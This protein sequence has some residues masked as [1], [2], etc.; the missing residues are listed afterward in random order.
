MDDFVN[1]TDPWGKGYLG[2]YWA[3]N[4]DQVPEDEEVEDDS[5]DWEKQKDYSMNRRNG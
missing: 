3:E 1:W 2:P 5:E 4:H